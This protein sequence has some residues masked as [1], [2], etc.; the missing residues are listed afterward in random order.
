M[1][2]SRLEDIQDSIV[3]GAAILDREIERLFDRAEELEELL[4]ESTVA[5]LGM[6]KVYCGEWES[7]TLHKL[8]EKLEQEDAETLE[9]VRE[10]GGG[11]TSDPTTSIESRRRKPIPRRQTRPSIKAIPDFS[12]FTA[13]GSS[14]AP[15]AEVPAAEVPSVEVP[16]TTSSHDGE[17]VL[18]HLIGSLS[19]DDFEQAVDKIMGM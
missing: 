7:R 19:M 8:G 10:K 6:E 1:V 5:I 13:S 9:K 2:L 11:P 3:C 18:P 12:F 4:Q 17:E 16:A 14:G 15:A